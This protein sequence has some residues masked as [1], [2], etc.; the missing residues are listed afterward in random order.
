M[1]QGTQDLFKI[2]ISKN[3]RSTNTCE[4]TKSYI[5]A[6]KSLH[7]FLVPNFI[8]KYNKIISYTFNT[9]FCFFFCYVLA[10][11][12]RKRGNIY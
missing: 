6:F 12:Y 10:V 8:I 11:C 2:K 3:E 5:K 9:F 7:A 4:S 1:R